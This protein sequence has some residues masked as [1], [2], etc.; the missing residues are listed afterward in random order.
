MAIKMNIPFT[1]RHL[2]GYQK[3]I[4]VDGATVRECMDDLMRK[5]PDTREFFNEDNRI[6]WIALNEELVELTNLDKKVAENDELNIVLII[7]GG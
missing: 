1:F 5:F 4:D 7:G 2:T 6:A 3:S